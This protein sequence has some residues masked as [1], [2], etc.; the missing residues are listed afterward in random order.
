LLAGDVVDD[1][2]LVEDGVLVDDGVSDVLDDELAESGPALHATSSVGS[3]STATRMSSHRVV[4]SP[5][6]MAEL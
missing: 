5:R 6:L 4:A 2:V 3:S 1:G